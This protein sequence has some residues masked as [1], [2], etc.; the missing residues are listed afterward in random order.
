MDRNTLLLKLSEVEFS[1]LDM[2]LFLN[3]HPHEKNAIKMYN[4]LV[5]EAKILRE[6]Y[7]RCYGP[8]FSFISKSKDD[9]FSW[10]DEPWP[11]N[12]EFN[13]RI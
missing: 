2:Q 11:W 6:E 10:I 1:A 4:E 5:S 13:V 8:L 7:E 9:Y 12:K 3:T